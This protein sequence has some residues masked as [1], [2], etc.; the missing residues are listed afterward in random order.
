MVLGQVEM[1]TDSGRVPATGTQSIQ[2]DLGSDLNE[3]KQ[4]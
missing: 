4:I 2:L 3:Y 1:P